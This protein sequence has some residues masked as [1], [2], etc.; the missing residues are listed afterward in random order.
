ME[1]PALQVEHARDRI[2]RRVAADQV[3]AAAVEDEPVLGPI[4]VDLLKEICRRG[5]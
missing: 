1:E 2:P 5:A 4:G 3:A